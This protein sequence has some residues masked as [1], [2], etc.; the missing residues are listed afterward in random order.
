MTR[1]WSFVGQVDVSRGPDCSG[2]NPDYHDLAGLGG[3]RFSWHATARISP[4]W[5]VMAGNLGSTADGYYDESIVRYDQDKQEWVKG[6]RYQEPQKDGSSD[7]RHTRKLE[8][9]TDQ[10]GVVA[11]RREHS[12]SVAGQRRRKQRPLYPWNRPEVGQ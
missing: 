12:R 2:C 9:Q 6:R 7:R 10:G 8:A 5:Q 1:R 11:A 3:V 4:F